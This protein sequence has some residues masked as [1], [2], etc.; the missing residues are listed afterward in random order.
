MATKVNLPQMVVPLSL[1]E[2][3]DESKFFEELVFNVYQL[4]KR[5]GGN[6]DDL[7]DSTA[8]ESF[9][10]SIAST[11]SQE[12]FND[13]A[14]L[15]DIIPICGKEF[16]GA[17]KESTY[18]AVDGDFIEAR[19]NAFINLD[20]HAAINDQLIIANGDGSRITIVGD[21]KYKSLENKT[22]LTK[23]GTSLYLHN[24]GEYWRIR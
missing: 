6:N 11:E 19:N 17:I 12:L 16:F 4:F 24:F 5:S 7:S 23:Q 18:T 13:S 21:V 8:S 22:I 1:T 3:R 15:E 10:T 20:P 9:E 14:Q 2:N